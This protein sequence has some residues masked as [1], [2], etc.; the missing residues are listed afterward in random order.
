MKARERLEQI[1]TAENIDFDCENRGI[2]H[3]YEKKSRFRGRR[4]TFPRCS[5]KAA[6]SGARL[7]PTEIKAIEPALRGE[8]YGGFFTPSDFTG[9][10]HKFTLGLAKACERLGVAMRLSDEVL[11]VTATDHGVT[12]ISQ[13]TEPQSRKDRAADG[14]QCVR[15][16]RRLRRRHVARA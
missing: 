13:S 12:I 11:S 14:G 16:R 2:L 5:P 9:D 3:F 4:A 6:S 1:A 10:I 15:P 8:Y 7:R